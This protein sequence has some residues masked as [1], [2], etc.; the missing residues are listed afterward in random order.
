ME[1]VQNLFK[2]IMDEATAIV[3]HKGFNYDVVFTRI[4]RENIIC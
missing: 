2:Y 4:S 1:R 3:P